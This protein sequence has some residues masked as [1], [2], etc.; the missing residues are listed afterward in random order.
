MGYYSG[1]K[2][3][4]GSILMHANGRT[5][6]YSFVDVMVYLV[7]VPLSKVPNPKCSKSWWLVQGCIL[8]YAAGI[9]SQ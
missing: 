8:P 6:K 9:G 3:Y 5:T 7:L 1:E 4:F 2:K